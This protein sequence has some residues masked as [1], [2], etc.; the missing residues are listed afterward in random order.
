MAPTRPLRRSRAASALAALALAGCS[1]GGAD[2]T[3][4]LVIEVR[5]S[6]AEQWASYTLTC[7]PDGGTHPNVAD[8]C[9]TLVDLDPEDLDAPGP[10]TMCAQVY[11]GPQQAKVR[12]VLNGRKVDLALSRTDA[13][14]SDRWDKLGADV[15]PVDLDWSN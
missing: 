11:G 9:R 13:C 14:Q 5:H 6:D 2:R 10:D 12:G 4:D 7:G 1:T 8:A 15:L 3:T